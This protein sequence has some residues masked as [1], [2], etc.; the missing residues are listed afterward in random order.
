MLLFECHEYLNQNMSFK[1]QKVN[2]EGDVSG[3][4][5]SAYVFLVDM[6]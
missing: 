3:V 6:K 2:E 5:P 1:Q 4:Q